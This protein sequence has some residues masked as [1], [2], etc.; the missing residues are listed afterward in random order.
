MIHCIYM[1]ALGLSAQRMV[2]FNGDSFVIPG[3]SEY[4]YAFGISCTEDM[5][6]SFIWVI[7]T[8]ICE[9]RVL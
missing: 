4:G 2:R 8:V 7:L 1:E 3:L 5:K 9:T 6:N